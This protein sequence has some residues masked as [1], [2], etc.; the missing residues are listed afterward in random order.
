MLAESPRPLVSCLCVTEAREAFLPWL[1]WGYDRQTWPNRELVIVDSSPKCADFGARSDVRVLHT[2]V[3]SVAQKRNLALEAARGQVVCWFDDDDWQHPERL[4]TLVALLGSGAPYAGCVRSWF[5][6]LQTETAAPFARS[7]DVLFNGAAFATD[8]ARRVEFDPR[9]LRGSD[10]RWLREIR[11]H[12]KYQG[13]LS[14]NSPLFLWLCHEQNL[15][16]GAKTRRLLEPLE[17]V[18]SDVGE[19]AW[20]DTSEHLAALRDRVR[21]GH[22]SSPRTAAASRQLV[23]RRGVSSIDPTT[24]GKQPRD[25]SLVHSPRPVSVVIKATCL[26]AGYL[27]TTV[28][29]MIRQARFAFRRRLIAVD[30]RSTFEGKYRHRASTSQADLDLALNSLVVK[31]IVDDVLDVDRREAVRDEIMG[32]YFPGSDE[33]LP[34]YARTGGPIYPTL[35]ALEQSPTDFVVQMDCDVLFHAPSESW[36][37]H[38]LDIMQRNSSVVLAM[39]HPGPPVGA[40]SKSLIRLNR[41]QG[42]WDSTLGAW[43]FSS[44]TTRY[45]LC[46]R[47]SLRGRLAAS[48]AK[49]R[50]PLERC[51][52]QALRRDRRFRVNVDGSLAWHLH[53]WSHASPFPEWAEALASLIEQGLYPNC[54]HGQYDLR[55]DDAHHRAAW[56]TLVEKH[57][58]L[59]SPSR[60]RSIRAPIERGERAP[61]P[62]APTTN[63]PCRNKQHFSSF[64][65]LAVVLPVRNR[66]LEQ[67]ERSID[68]L[69]WQSAGPPEEI[70]LVSLG[71]EPEFDE[72]YRTLERFPTLTLLRTGDECD[73]WNKPLALNVGLRATSTHLPV[74]M[75][76]D[77]DVILAHNF[78]DVVLAR[79]A[80]APPCFLLCRALDLPSNKPVP[81]TPQELLE[82]F[83]QLRLRARP[84]PRHGT[85]GIQ[86]CARDFFHSVRGYDED[87]MWWGAMDGDM[88]RRAEARGLTVEWIDDRTSM[89][90]QWHPKKYRALRDTHEQALARQAWGRNHTMVDARAGKVVRNPKGWGGG[91]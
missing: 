30:R 33:A 39:A 52:T 28:P 46:D 55:L 68:S 71:S 50:L 72:Q 90:H 45:F 57:S 31:G 67:V 49:R 75:T 14:S 10:S 9:R 81:T 76:M 17:R 38:G 87:L 79:L 15:S 37:A 84:R 80:M 18:I 41:R 12:A 47:R 69:Y 88:V 35:F 3:R 60:P 53:A 21:S 32:R 20:A 6:N 78:L 4:S 22:D 64:A 91:V 74:A 89:L 16:N 70:L 2:E 19:K 25:H 61:R 24:A 62:A 44:A 1:L 43:R 51:I 13:R 54:Q 36:V 23:K 83:E 58:D 40:G 27:T 66:P 77:A 73:P 11:R 85:G 29:H 59:Q 34:E 8:L 48:D 5:V 65:P 7:Q 56:K 26:D 82:R 86:A 42:T 63:P